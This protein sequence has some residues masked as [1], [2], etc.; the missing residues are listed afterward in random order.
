MMLFRLFAS[1]P[2]GDCGA[3]FRQAAKHANSVYPRPGY[4][5]HDTQDMSNISLPYQAY[6]TLLEHR[7]DS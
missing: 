7:I 2:F 4:I 6:V 3:L 1:L 5:I